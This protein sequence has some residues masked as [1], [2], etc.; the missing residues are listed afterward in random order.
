VFN[1]LVGHDLESD[2]LA[3]HAR[4]L[5]L[6][7]GELLGRHLLRVA[8][9]ANHLV[10]TSGAGI[11]V[12]EMVQH[13]GRDLDASL[14]GEL[15]RGD[16]GEVPILVQHAGR[17]L[18]TVPR[19]NRKARLL[20][21]DYPA[22]ALAHQDDENG[23]GCAADEDDARD[24]HILEHA[25]LLVNGL[26]GRVGLDLDEADVRAE[27]VDRLDHDFTHRELRVDRFDP[28]AELE[29]RHA[30]DDELVRDVARLADDAHGNAVDEDGD[31]FLLGEGNWARAR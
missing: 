10:A 19:A 23:D 12:A 30:C 2:D 26:D 25:V 28:I 16:A 6:E 15:L 21:P 22:L 18:H 14:L 7:V 13:A 5:A 20:G 4:A 24:G 9:E 27:H 17:E 29:A 8:E 31:G 3:L 1:P 11:D